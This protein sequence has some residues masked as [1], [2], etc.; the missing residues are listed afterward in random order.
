MIEWYW[1]LQNAPSATS[2]PAVGWATLVAQLGLGAVFL[3]LYLDERKYART[4]NAALVSLA[5][6]MLPV[7]KDAAST[8]DAVQRGM[9]HQV[10]R[11][12]PADVD[13]SATT[14]QLQQMLDQLRRELGR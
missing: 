8:L 6:R 1:L 12:L 3:Y 11:N 9:E 4:T 2:D 7:L 13:L 10:Q 14:R 5:E